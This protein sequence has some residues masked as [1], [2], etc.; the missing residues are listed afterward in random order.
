MLADLQV[1]HQF[2]SAL[3]HEEQMDLS[4][5]RRDENLSEIQD[6]QDPKFNQSDKSASSSRSK[7]SLG[8]KLNKIKNILLCRSTLTAN[9]A[10][11]STNFDLVPIASANDL[12][13]DN[14]DSTTLTKTKSNSSSMISSSYENN[15]LANFYSQNTAVKADDL[16]YQHVTQLNINNDNNSCC[17]R[18]NKISEEASSETPKI[19]KLSNCSEE[20]LNFI[21]CVANPHVVSNNTDNWSFD[22]NKTIFE[23]HLDADAL[24][25]FESICNHAFNSEPEMSDLAPCKI[26]DTD[27]YINDRHQSVQN[28]LK[29]IDNE[30]NYDR[31]MK[32]LINDAKYG[33][34]FNLR[35]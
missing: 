2:R 16:F 26:L 9:L 31:K 15:S 22:F 12:S 27:E 11:E 8:S 7:S 14:Y 6:Y 29:L 5:R 1:H 24:G 10:Q 23:R 30:E 28:F 32:K 33:L 3:A 35:F 34:S 19:D 20:K 18:S 4:M 21:K 17:N 25:D 13:L